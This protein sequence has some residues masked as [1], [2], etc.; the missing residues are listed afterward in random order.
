MK[1]F[2]GSCGCAEQEGRELIVVD[3]GDRGLG[4]ILVVRFVEVSKEGREW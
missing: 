1:G 4:S 2:S 3:V